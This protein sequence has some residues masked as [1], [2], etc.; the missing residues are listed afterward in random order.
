M[1]DEVIISER[2]FNVKGPAGQISQVPGERI[3]TQVLDITVKS[4]AFNDRTRMIRISNNAGAA[5]WYKIG[6]T[7]VSA[8][9]NTDGNEYLGSGQFVDE[10]VEA[11]QFID[12]AADA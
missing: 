8:A 5:I 6:D 9:A 10:P 11:G 1:A 4:A 12:T 2:A 3:T 7:N